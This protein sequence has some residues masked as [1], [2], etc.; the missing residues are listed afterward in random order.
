MPRTCPSIELFSGTGGLAL[1]LQNAGFNHVAFF[2]KNR[3]ACV[4]LRN[5]I[6]KFRHDSESPDIF[7]GDV[8][9]VEFSDF[10][11]AVRFVAGGPPCQPFSLGGRH[12]ANLDERDMFPEA[13]RAVRE[14]A[15]EAFLFENVK[16]LARKAFSV[17]F[18]Y[19]LLQLQHPEVMIKES[20]TWEEHLAVLERH[21]TSGKERGLGYN[22]VARVVNAA[23]YGVP[24]LR[25]RVLIAGFRNDK[26]VEWSFP[27]PAYSQDRLLYSQWVTGEYWEARDIKP[28]MSGRPSESRII[29]AR[30]SVETGTAAKHPWRTVR[31]AL[32]G[33]EDPRG[34]TINNIPD[35]HEYRSGAR[36]YPG[37]SG[38][39]LDWPSKALKAG[40]HGVPGG[41]NMMVL[42]DGT[43]R[44][45]TVR[46]AARIQTFPDTFTF[47][48]SWTE[49]MRQLGNAVP[50]KL[51]NVI[52]R[53]L[54]EKIK[55]SNG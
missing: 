31:D 37:H 3:D 52:G 8:R 2:E 21:H 29:Q 14:M 19:I 46:E 20:Q 18:E 24:Q 47:A 10:A 51:A 43:P 33:L 28:R 48:S 53:S 55:V 30:R 36:T 49:S 16:G 27:P 39:V 23:D 50:V 5:N 38:S 32:S 44:Y 22:V 45:Y 25:H 13:V 7:E 42:D 26:N 17:Y 41:E 35:N 11:G 9:D 54:M 34:Y 12:R 15:P 1:G 4:N 40:V 6:I